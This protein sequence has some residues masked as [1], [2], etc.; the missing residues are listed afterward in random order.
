[1]LKFKVLPIL[2]G[3]AALGTLAFAATTGRAATTS[4]TLHGFC[5]STACS[6]N[7]TITPANQ[8]PLTAF[9]FNR[10]PA[11]NSG[12]EN[13]D[14]VLVLLSPTNLGSTVGTY[15]ASGGV[16]T[17]TKSLSLFSGTPFST[18]NEELAT[19]LGTTR[20]GG[21]NDQ[22]SAFQAG[23]T[24][25]GFPATSF[26]VYTAD[27]GSVNFATSVSITDNVTVPISSEYLGLVTCSGPI[28]SPATTTCP[29]LGTVQDGTAPS[30]TI[31][32]VPAP[33]IGHGL[34]VLLAVGGVLFGGK[35]LENLKKR[36]LH[37]A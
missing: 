9:G 6:D 8:N 29:S 33:V 1:M 36:H 13:P 31:I 19:Y 17:S 10:S 28:A 37:A 16:T 7:G 32:V 5:T 35:F 14:F 30:S 18:P 12:L 2:A 26:F 22:L 21:P 23:Q 34:L 11:S 20:T 25:Q 24:N 4:M 27:F 15:T 3:A